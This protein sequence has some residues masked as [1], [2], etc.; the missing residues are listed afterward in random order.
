M[1]HHGP[2]LILRRLPLW[3]A[4][5]VPILAALEE[6]IALR[7]GGEQVSGERTWV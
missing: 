1:A 5:H 6:G 7:P 3:G 4:G 2:F